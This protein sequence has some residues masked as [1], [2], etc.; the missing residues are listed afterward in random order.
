MSTEANKALVRRWFEAIDRG[1]VN[2]GK[3][4]NAFG[5]WIAN[6]ERPAEQY[7]GRYQLRLAEAR[8]K[9][10]APIDERTVILL[11]STPVIGSTVVT[12]SPLAK[13]TGPL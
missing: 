8:K 4:P 5:E 12:L 7:R 6:V 3:D 11:V 10:P 13:V 1:D 9:T 2:F